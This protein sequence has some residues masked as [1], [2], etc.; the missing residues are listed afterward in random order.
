MQLLSKSSITLIMTV[1]NQL[2]GAAV[3]HE[4]VDATKYF[5]TLM[6]SKHAH[7]CAVLSWQW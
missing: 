7:I 5:I 3:K 6:A 2:A 4:I 1:S